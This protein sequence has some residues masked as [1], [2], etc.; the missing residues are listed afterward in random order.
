MHDEQKNKI[1][2]KGTRFFKKSEIDEKDKISQ[3][4]QDGTECAWLT[5]RV[6]LLPKVLDWH[7]VCKINRIVQDLRHG[8]RL[9][10]IVLLSPIV[11]DLHKGCRIVKNVRLTNERLTQYMWQCQNFTIETKSVR[12][13]QNVQDW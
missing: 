13:T 1:N 7:K 3:K 10:Q 5:K 4:V 2:I 8:A 6:G 9:G 11:Q 12:L